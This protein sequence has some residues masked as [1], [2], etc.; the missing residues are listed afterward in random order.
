MSET[1]DVDEFLANANVL[2]IVH[3]FWKFKSEIEHSKIFAQ[4]IKESDGKIPITDEELR[5]IAIELKRIAKEDDGMIRRAKARK[6]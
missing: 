3:V 2:D 6:Q 5:H 1:Y 4:R